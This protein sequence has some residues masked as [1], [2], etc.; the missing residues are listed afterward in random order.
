MNQLDV[1]LYE[2][3]QQV[4]EKQRERLTASGQLQVL[5]PKASAAQSLKQGSK[6]PGSHTGMDGQVPDGVTRPLNGAEKKR[7]QGQLMQQLQKFL[8]R[9]GTSKYISPQPR[10]SAVRLL[11]HVLAAATGRLSVCSSSA[12]IE[13]AASGLKPAATLGSWS[14]Q[15]PDKLTHACVI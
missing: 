15:Q 8:S 5:P 7:V 11:R 13:T 6:L 10:L 2:H 9:K 4:I 3:A 12:A 14:A 1:Q